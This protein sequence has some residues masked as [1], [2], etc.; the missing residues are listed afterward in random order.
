MTMYEGPSH[1]SRAEGEVERAIAGKSFQP[2]L[3]RRDDVSRGTEL[4]S[5]TPLS[6]KLFTGACSTQP[7]SK[8]RLAH[9]KVD[10][11]IT[12]SRP[13]CP[14]PPRR[15]SGAEH[16]QLL[17]VSARQGGQHVWPHPASEYPLTPHQ[18]TKYPALIQLEQKTKVPKA[19]AVLGIAVL[20][21]LLILINAA[22]LPVS[23]LIG[24]G[25]P[26]YLSFKAIESPGVQDDVQWLTYWT[27]FGAFNLVETLALRIVLYYLPFYFV[28]KTAFILWLQLPQFRVST[29][30]SS[31][32]GCSLIMRHGQ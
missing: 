17:C 1:W 12:D 28:F 2:A 20:A 26:A 30:P 7:H 27:V 5:E 32:T 4:C 16:C 25:L 29:S 31:G 22:A 19:A 10:V 13:A 15:R 11:S 21:V 8:R 9:R 6:S 24:W 18:L 3:N 14:E 23:N